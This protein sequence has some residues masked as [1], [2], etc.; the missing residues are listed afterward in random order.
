MVA[1]ASRTQARLLPSS[2]GTHTSIQRGPRPSRGLGARAATPTSVGGR[3]AGRLGSEVDKTRPPRAP[4]TVPAAVHAARNMKVISGTSLVL[5]GLLLLHA[6]RTLG[7]APPSRGEGAC[8][9]W[10][11]LGERPLTSSLGGRSLRWAE[12]KWDAGWGEGQGGRGASRLVQEQA[13][14]V[15]SLRPRAGVT[16][17]LFC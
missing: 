3:L 6:P 10:G 2:P 1:G 5:C 14:M 11:T 17:G 15:T 7:L 12:A 16:L 8:G 4:A 13:E 9:R